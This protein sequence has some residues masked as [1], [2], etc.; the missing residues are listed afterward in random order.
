MISEKHYGEVFA[1]FVT[2]KF[3]RKE[4]LKTTQDNKTT[5]TNIQN[6]LY[7][8]PQQYIETH[9]NGKRTNSDNVF[10]RKCVNCT[11][12]QAC[13]SFIFNIALIIMYQYAADATVSRHHP[14]LWERKVTSHTMRNIT[15]RTRFV[16]QSFRFFFT[17][18]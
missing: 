1:A 16:F 4:P 15:G 18:R 2:E 10:F 6:T 13:Q 17:Y 12:H 11:R 3:V 5:I 7:N 14:T 9:C 8:K